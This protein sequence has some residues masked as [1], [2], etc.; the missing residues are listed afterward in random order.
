MR[1]GFC[2]K[3]INVQDRSSALVP[4][5]ARPSRRLL[6]AGA[7]SSQDTEV[8]SAGARAAYGMAPA[9][10]RQ[11]PPQRGASARRAEAIPAPGET[12]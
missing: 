10:W 9:A 1:N 2:L 5:P 4:S 8:R 7:G 11:R 3:E 12:T 6:L